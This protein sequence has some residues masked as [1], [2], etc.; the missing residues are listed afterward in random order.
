LSLA[1]LTVLRERFSPRA[2]ILLF[3]FPPGPRGRRQY[4]SQG[5][6]GRSVPG[7][8]GQRAH[9]DSLASQTDSQPWDCRQ[10]SC[11]PGKAWMRF[12]P[13]RS[14]DHDLAHTAD[15][16]HTADSGSRSRRAGWRLQRCAWA[17]M[18]SHRLWPRPRSQPCAATAGGAHAVACV[19]HARAYREGPQDVRSCDLELIAR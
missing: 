19:T 6:G 17:E 16:T 11:R 3:A 18:R 9:A 1:P 5:C 2:V 15:L 13:L 14:V 10:H 8:A 4:Q 12:R 7:A